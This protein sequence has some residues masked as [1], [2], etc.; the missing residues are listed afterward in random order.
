M[1]YFYT[2]EEWSCNF[3]E[4]LRGVALFSLLFPHYLVLEWFF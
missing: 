2:I 3:F 4:L 1:G